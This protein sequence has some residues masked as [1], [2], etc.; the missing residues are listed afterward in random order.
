MPSSNTSPPV[1]S[2]QITLEN[3]ATVAEELREA[4]ARKRFNVVLLSTPI[5]DGYPSAWTAS[6][7][8]GVGAGF[9]RRSRENVIWVE[10]SPEQGTPWEIHLVVW[11]DENAPGAVLR[12]GVVIL[13]Y[14]DAG[15]WHFGILTPN[16]DG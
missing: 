5:S 9:S 2:V 7:L 1:R 6:N 15:R 10:L 11:P 12:D 4:V 3:A 13:N 8:T 16:S 14:W